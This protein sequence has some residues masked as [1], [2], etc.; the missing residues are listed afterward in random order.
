MRQPRELW[1]S[2]I[3]LVLATAGNAIGLGNFLRFPVQCA[4]NG[5]GAFMVP[6]LIA[7][8]LF[9]L[10]L[11]WCEWAMGRHGGH[12]GHGT[13]PG[14]FYHLWHH[15]ISKYLGTFGIL[16]SFGVGVYYLYV[17]SWTLAYSFFSLTGKYMGITSQ[18]EMHLF[19]SSFQ[20]VTTSRYFDSLDVSY[21]FY[22]ICLALCIYIL[23]KGVVKGL[24]RLAK[25]GMP[26]LFL[27]GIILM[28]RIFTLGTPNPNLP[29]NSINAGMGFMWNPDFAS[30][31]NPKVWLAAAGQVFFTLSVGFGA[32]Q[33]YAS[34]IKKQ[35][36]VAL[37]GLSTAATNSFAEII[38]GGSIAIP[39]AVAFFGITGTR[40]VAQGGA[41]NLGFMAMPLIF[42]KIPLG[43]VFGTIWFFLLFIAGLTS[44]VAIVQPFM[45]FLQDEF[46]LSRKVATAIT[47]ATLFL[48]GQPVIFLLKYGFLDEMDFWL[49]TFGVTLFAVI[50]VVVFVWLFGPKKAWAEI[51]A[52]ADIKV[53]RVFYYI[54]KY[55]TPTFL[56]ILL[57]TW[58]YQ[59]GM[60]TILL[61]GVSNENLPFVIGVRVMLLL[62]LLGLVAGVKYSFAHHR[63]VKR[64]VKREAQ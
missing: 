37:N 4:Q 49:G 3:G 28:V 13:T 9:G 38:L 36:D 7:L 52:G 21:I 31:K 61:K 19:L 44:A 50:E 42:Q 8:L 33:T 11:M 15:R 64:G 57:G 27:F 30:L 22:L 29:H 1:K 34:Y 53:P 35:D 40:M 46:Q 14:I 5:G 59:S 2:R 6:Y 55:V 18:D 54:L 43:Q 39:I 62:M 60:D 25:Y 51:T 17:M 32:I 24:E 63:L 58:L 20:G 56:V 12:R 45:A 16:I 23:S 26:L 10:P 47:G 41:F 48:L